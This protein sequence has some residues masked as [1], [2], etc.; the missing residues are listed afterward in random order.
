VNITLGQ[1]AEQLDG[2]LVGGDPARVITGIVGVDTAGADDVTYILDARRLAEAEASPAAAILAPAGTASAK[3]L[4]L[5]A[6]PRGAFGRALALFDWRRT[7]APGIHPL[8]HVDPAATVHPT[9]SVGAHAAV[10]ADVVIAAG[11]VLHPHVVVGDTVQVGARSVLHANVTIYPHCTIGA[12]VIIHSGTVIGADGLGFAPGADGWQKIPHLGTVIIEDVV[13]IGANVTIDRGTTGSTVI[14]RGTKIDNLVQIAHNVRIGADCMIVAQVGLAGS[15]TLEHG[16]I[17]AGQAGVADHKHV[18][19]G[20]RVAVRS[21]VTRDVPA[22]ATVS[23]FP[24]QPHADQL[25][26]EAALRRVPDL[27]EKVKRLE[28]RVKELE[29]ERDPA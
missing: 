22:G 25:K 8:A 12:D 28:K 9:A 24:T 7:P 1:L 26:L 10:G 5:L 29:G 21:G 3:P 16:V 11:A 14:G 18:G 23:G 6:D 15:S 17:V 13:E 27:L 4:I 20:A 19:A 2:T